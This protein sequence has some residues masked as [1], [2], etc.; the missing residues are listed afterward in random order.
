[1]LRHFATAGRAPDVALLEPVAAHAGRTARDVLAE[2]DREDFL[3][4]D[5]DGRIRAAYPFSATPTSHR[6]RI[7]GG[8]EVFSMC[9]VDALGI[10]AMLGRDAV[11]SS[12]DPVT[13]EP[14]TVTSMGGTT[15]WEPDSAVVFVGRRGCSGPAAAVCCDTLNFFTSRASASTWSKRH[16]NVLG[17]IVG[18]ARAEE[19]G[20]QVFGPLLTTAPPDSPGAP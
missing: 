4:L 7:D 10:P 2:L 8:A 19:L 12:T 3:T 5:E 9:A 1:M 11:I 18:Q 15:V 13:G 14:V 6:V 20:R 17:E 16:P